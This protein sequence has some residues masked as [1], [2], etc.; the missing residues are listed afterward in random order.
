MDKELTGGACPPN[1][2]STKKINLP[3]NAFKQHLFVGGGVRCKSAENTGKVQNKCNFF[4]ALRA[5]VSVIIS[6]ELQR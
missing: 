4:R 1:H 2:I 6:I 5:C 3:E